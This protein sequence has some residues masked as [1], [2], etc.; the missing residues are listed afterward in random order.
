VAEAE[1]YRA[2]GTEP[3]WPVIIADGRMTYEAPEGGFSVR[4]PQPRETRDGRIYQSR[5]ITLHVWHDRCSYGMSDRVYAETVRAVVNGR[6]LQGCGGA[7]TEPAP[8]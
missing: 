3:F 4:A 7:F 5:R 6:E 2:L 1:P 8:S